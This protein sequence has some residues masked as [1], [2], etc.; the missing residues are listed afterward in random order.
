MPEGEP[1]HRLGRVALPLADE[2]VGGR[3]AERMLDPGVEIGQGERDNR[4]GK[5]LR[6][7]LRQGAV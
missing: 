5:A 6:D 1:D 2:L 4:R 7:G 3:R